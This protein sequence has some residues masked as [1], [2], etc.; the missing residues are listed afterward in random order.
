MVDQMGNVID[1]IVRQVMKRDK[2]FKVEYWITRVFD[3]IEREAKSFQKAR[4]KVMEK[5][6]KKGDDDVP[7]KDGAGQYI[8]ETDEDR[9]NMKAEYFE[10]LE[11]EIEIPMKPITIDLMDSNMPKFNTEEMKI[12][13]PIMKEIEQE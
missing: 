7:L 2:P 5:H 13:V 9:E 1:P 8:Y 6:A 3:V 11:T 4:M 10:F 12:I